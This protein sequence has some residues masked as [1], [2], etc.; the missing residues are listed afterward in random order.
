MF[1]GPLHEYTSLLKPLSPVFVTT[2]DGPGAPFGKFKTPTSTAK[3]INLALDVLEPQFLKGFFQRIPQSPE[4]I[5]FFYQPRG[6][7][8]VPRQ[9]CVIFF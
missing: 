1:P 3:Y 7:V 4:K 5:A 8:E 2:L 6:S 9:G